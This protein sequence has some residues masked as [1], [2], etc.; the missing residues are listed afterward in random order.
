MRKI[1]LFLLILGFEIYAFG[2]GAISLRMGAAAGAPIPTRIDSGSTGNFHPTWTIGLS[3]QGARFGHFGIGCDVIYT[4]K[5]AS[6]GSFI[7][8]TDTAII[9]TVWGIPT[10]VN[11]YY[12][13]E[14]KGRMNLHYIDV[15]IQLSYHVGERFRLM[16]GPSISF[17]IA[18]QDTGI[19]HIVVG[20]NFTESDNA[21]NNWDYVRRMDI[22][23]MGGFAYDFPFGL[24]LD[25][26][27]QRGFRNVYQDSFASTNPNASVKLYQT[28]GHFGISYPLFKWRQTI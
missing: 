6:Y 13:G 14:V 22:G 5:M 3:S 4:R 24:S 11:T 10:L 9:Q 20:N 21:F 1:F 19:A 15:P 12:Q 7:P 8:R 27:L 16:A 2:Q 25:L 17:L 23:W 28:Y 18:G 26:R